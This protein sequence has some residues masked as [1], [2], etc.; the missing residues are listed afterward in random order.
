MP[1]A[2]GSSTTMATVIDY[3]V[4]RILNE[5]YI[6]AHELLT[7]HYTQLTRLADALLEHE[8]LDRAQFEALLQNDCS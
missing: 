6:M 4:Q 7:K 3:E 8:Q 1:A 2:R 5:A